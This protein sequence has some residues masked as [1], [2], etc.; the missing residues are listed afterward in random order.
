MIRRGRGVALPDTGTIDSPTAASEY[1]AT[2][3]R[4]SVMMFATTSAVLPASPT[5]AAG[6]IWPNY[7]PLAGKRP[8]PVVEVNLVNAFGQ[9]T[10]SF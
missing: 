2:L 5:S 9:I 6:Q 7:W 4:Q 10:T 1:V 8:R 3:E